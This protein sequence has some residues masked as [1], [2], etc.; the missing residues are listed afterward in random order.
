M[1][2]PGETNS[3]PEQSSINVIP[4]PV[5]QRRKIGSTRRPLKGNNVTAVSDVLQK[6]TLADAKWEKDNVSE[7]TES[8]SAVTDSDLLL[9]HHGTEGAGETD[10][11]TKQSGIS[12]IPGDLQRKETNLESSPVVQR[13]KMGSTRRPLK[14]NKG[15]RKG[16]EL[17][18]ENETFNS[19]FLLDVEKETFSLENEPCP[20]ES[21]LQNIKDGAEEQEKE[22]CLENDVGFVEESESALIQSYSSDLVSEESTALSVCNITEP[23]TLTNIQEESF[24]IFGDVERVAEDGEADLHLETESQN[25]TFASTSKA[26]ENI[27]DVNVLVREAEVI[28]GSVDSNVTAESDVL[29][30]DSLADAKLETSQVSENAEDVAAVTDSDLLVQHEATEGAEETDLTPE[31]SCISVIAGDSHRED[32]NLKSSPVVQ[33]RK[34]GSTRRPLKGNKGQRKGRELQDENETFNSEFLLNVEKETFGLENK[35]CPDESTLQDIKDK[36]EEKEK[37]ICVKN[38]AV[39]E[40]SESGHIQTSYSSDLVLEESTALSV[41]NITES[42]TLTKVHEESQ[43]NAGDVERESVDGGTNLQL[44]SKSQNQTCD[45]TS[46]T[47]ENTHAVNFLVREAEGI[48]ESVKVDWNV[49]P[50]SA[51][52]QKDTFADARLKTLQV[53]ENT[54]D[55]SAVADSDLLVQ[56]EATELSGETDSITEQSALNIIPGDSHREEANSKSSPV[57]Q[58]RKMGSTRRPLKG[59]KGQRKGRELHDENEKFNSEFLLDVEKETFSL[60][61]EPCPDESTLQNIKDGAEEQEKEICVK[62]DAGLVEESESALIQ[63]YS[64]DLVSEESTAL[65]VCNITESQT[66]TKVLEESE[67]N[68]GDVERES[69]DGGTNLQLESESQNQTCDSTSKTEENIHDVNVLVREAEVFGESVKVDCNVTAESD[70]LQKDTFADTQLKTLQ[71]SE[72]TE[73]ISAVAD[74]DLL[75]QHEATE[76]SGETDSI[77]EQSALNIIPGDSHREEANSKSSPVVQRRKMGS[78]RRPLKE[79]KGQRKGREMHDEKETIS[80][81]N[82]LNEEKE[83]FGLEDEPCPDES[84]LQNIKDGAEEQETEM[85]VK[86]DAGVIEESESAL[87]Q[88]SYG[89]DLVSEESTALRICNITESQ[90]LTEI[91]EESQENAD[92]EPVDGD[93]KPQRKGQEYPDENDTVDSKNMIKV[94]TPIFS[95]DD[96]P[97]PD[98]FT[99]ESL[100]DGAEAHKIK[101][102]MKN[103]VG[104]V[105]E[106][107]S[108]FIQLSNVSDLGPE[109]S[110]ALTVCN[111]TESQTLTNIPEESLEIVGD[112]ERKAVD[113][114]TDLQLQT[115]PHNQTFAST[116]KAEENIHDGNVLVREADVIGESVKVDSNVTAESDVLQKDT[117]ADAKLETFQLFENTDDVSAVTDSDLL[118]QHEATEAPG[119][120]DSIT[121]QSGIN[122]IP[123]GSHKE[124]ANSKSSPVVQRRKMG[125]TR[126]P[127]KGNKGQRKGR[128]MHDEKETFSSANML[129]EEKETFGL[130]DE[131]CPDESTLQNIKD[132]AAEQ[133]TEKCVKNDA[134]VVEES[135]SALIQSSY[136]SDLVSEESTALT[137]CNITESQT[138]TNIH[139]E[140][141]EIIER[142]AVDGDIDLQLEAE[143]Q[144]RTFNSTSKAEENINAVNVLVREA[145]V[146]RESDTIENKVTLESALIQN[147]IFVNANLETLKVSEKTE[148]ISADSDLLVQQE[149]ME[150]GGETN[151]IPEQSGISVIPSPVVQRRKIGSTRRPLKGNNVTAESDVLQ[152]AT[153]ADAKLEK[154]NVSE[155]TESLSAVTDSNL[156]LQHHGTEGAGETDSIPKQSGISIIPGDLQRKETNLESSPVIQRRKMGSTRRPL[157]GNKGQRKGRELHDENE[158]FN[159]EFLLDVQKETF[160]LEDEPCPD[161]STLQNI[162]DGAEEQEK[163]LCV[164]NDASLVGESESALIQSSYGS[165]LASGETTA[166]SVCNITE[167]QTLTKTHEEAWEIVGDV[168]RA[169]VEEDTDLQSKTESQ[170]QT[171]VSISE[172]EEN[173]HDVN[174][175]VREAEVTGES[176][177]LDSNVTAESDVIQKDTLADAELETLQVSENTEDVSAVTDTDFLVQHHGTERAEGTDTISVQSGIN[178]IPRESHGEE[179]NSKSSPVV[180]RRKMGSTRRPLKGNKGQRKGQELDD[181]KETF[182]CEFLLDVEKET[183][184]LENEPCPD[185]S[186]LQ[187]MKDGAEEQEKEIC[188]END[189]GL[190]EES[191]SALIQ[192]Y[193]SDLVS[194]ESTALSV[195]NITES[196]TLTKI[197]EESWEIVG[198]VERESVDGDTDLQLETESQNQTCDSTSKAEQNIHDVNVLVRE[199]EG[200]G[201]SVKVDSN[202]I[203]ESDVL[204][205]ATLADPKLETLHVSENTK[206]VS[207]VTDSDLL[208]Q[209]EPTVEAG[210]TD[211]VPEKSGISIIPG[212]SHNEEANSKSS[213]VV[214]RRKMGS[215]RRPLKGNKGQ[216]KGREL[217]DENETLNNEIR[218]DVEKETFGLENEPCPDESALQNIKVGA[219]EQEKEICVKND[220]GVVEE[221]ESDLI[222]SFYGSD[223]VSEESTALSVCH[224]E[225]AQTLTISHEQFQNNPGDAERA[226]VV[227][228]AADTEDTSETEATVTMK[229]TTNTA[230]HVFQTSPSS[231][232]DAFNISTNVEED[233]SG[234]TDTIFKQ[235]N[236]NVVHE[237]I[238]RGEAHP[239]LSPVVQKRKMGSTRRPLRG[240][241]GQKK[242]NDEKE[243]SFLENEPNPDELIYTAMGISDISEAQTHVKVHEESQDN[244][245]VVEKATVGEST[246]SQTE[247]KVSVLVREAEVPENTVVI[248]T[249]EESYLFQY[250]SDSKL[251]ISDYEHEAPVI[252]NIISKQSD[253]SIP[254]DS[255]KEEENSQL[256]PVVQKRKM[257]STR[258]PLKGN[259]GQGKQREESKVKNRDNEA[260]SEEENTETHSKDQEQNVAKDN[261]NI[262]DNVNEEKKATKA[263]DT[264][265]QELCEQEQRSDVS[266]THADTSQDETSSH[267][268]DIPERTV[269][270][271]RESTS[272]PDLVLSDVLLMTEAQTY[273]SSE[274]N[275]MGNSSISI[276]EVHEMHADSNTSKRKMGSTRKRGKRMVNEEEEEAENTIGSGAT[277]S[278][279][280]LTPKKLIAESSVHKPLFSSYVINEDHDSKSDVQTELS[281]QDYLNS[282]INTEPMKERESSPD[283]VAEM[284]SDFALGHVDTEVVPEQ[285]VIPEEPHKDQANLNPVVQKRKMG[286]TRKTLRG[287]KGQR[288]EEESKE[289]NEGMTQD[290]SRELHLASESKLGEEVQ[291]N[292]SLI[293]MTNNKEAKKPEDELDEM[294][295]ASSI[296]QFTE[297]SSETLSSS[298][299]KSEKLDSKDENDYH[300]TCEHENAHQICADATKSLQSES[301]PIERRR[302]MGS[303]RKNIGRE[304]R[305][306]R[307]RDGYEDTEI[308][309]TNLQMSHDPEMSSSGITAEEQTTEDYSNQSEDSLLG[310]IQR[311]LKTTSQSASN[312]ELIIDEPKSN[313]PE[314]SEIRSLSPSQSL[315]TL[316]DPNSPERRRRKM[317]S[318]RKNPKR[319]FKAERED[320]DK[321][322][323]KTESNKE[324]ITEGS[325]VHNI[326]ED[327]PNK[328]YLDVPSA[329]TSSQQEESDSPVVQESASPSTKR[330]FGSRRANK[331]KLGRL[332]ASDGMTESE[333][334]DH[335]PDG[336]AVED[337]QHRDGSMGCGTSVSLQPENLPFSR[338]Y[339]VAPKGTGEE[340]QVR[341]QDRMTV[342]VKNRDSK[343]VQFN[344][345][346]VGNSCVGKTSFIR[347]FHEGQFTEDYRS[348]IGV[349]TFVQTVELPD[350]TVKLQIWDTA[351]QERFHS[352]TTQVFHKAE[353]LLLM[354]EITCSKSFISIRDWIS[355]ARERAQ[356][357]VVMMLLGNKNDSV[358]REVQIQEG[359]DLAREYNIHF[360]ECSAANGANV[361]ESMRTLAELLVQRKRKREEHTTLRREPQQKKSGCC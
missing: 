180:Q 29:Q 305:M 174:V 178:I 92:G 276:T 166:L 127:L 200:I 130:E 268:L 243:I 250:V 80:S 293:N 3:I 308:I 141:W 167:P 273:L 94:E 107:E 233:T 330:K 93:F 146:T 79:N 17:H 226:A 172:A 154:D 203:A 347:R 218:F 179:A 41:C 333:D 304:G 359:A 320:E 61:N 156:L 126:R 11:N 280:T 148:D 343:V 269:D 291:Q 335:K 78:T 267:L 129:N 121:E 283:V 216:R 241:K 51:V 282:T 261:M 328:E 5:V 56:H 345:V 113:G 234:D 185:E 116:S 164:K 36:A 169:T 319:Q 74:S 325:L 64:S 211:T 289:I 302:K 47:E 89:S 312:F 266:Q 248:N 28:G 151:S 147:N 117:L 246:Q 9:Q 10:S 196:Q 336:S 158:T 168:E 189:V 274:D 277:S 360:M 150:E 231:S 99:L 353:G 72:N 213:P 25:Q 299:L 317:G 105:E 131:P 245:E 67:N 45:S 297:A 145:E 32:S 149:A 292:Q 327:P 264:S 76:V 34:M 346:M 222:Q 230:S 58:R 212:D 271:V 288:K 339:E 354:Y 97:N 238:Y 184:S 44:E 104:L 187:N 134:G 341:K 194:E 334:G 337:R 224:I 37:K 53:S 351:G 253:F 170:N 208:V 144:N 75:V 137:I 190:V 16:Q 101:M 62:N 188:L 232:T 57:V 324:E 42:Q 111:I 100:I 95:M 122:I 255:H 326:T 311:M 275:V 221:Y 7:N 249:T 69:V 217:Q 323:Q 173:I 195:C 260:G 118:I 270:F 358:N 181:E 331:G 14:G 103:D 40:E 109:E 281:D 114:D 242:D 115:E 31:Q 258:R 46:K 199:A 1:E 162:K 303:T 309:D 223:L 139:K 96:Q 63:S 98:E 2:E 23:Q 361:S 227:E 344:V 265:M 132:G 183:F 228:D 59:N 135:E 239:K 202:V 332:E 251:T 204:Q 236:I 237:D 338:N 138:L 125:S 106:S 39:V 124:E 279:E 152:K 182:H 259:K 19:E 356:D 206:D 33:R 123:G 163:E 290:Q 15:Q 83:T 294:P 318:T 262:I 193:S 355:Q 128:E 133:E 52:L 102:F 136:G 8:L 207:A 82:M 77:T 26:E 110:T 322:D 27:H 157:K 286:S 252:P 18:D 205:K 54:E 329:H 263:L 257:G 191:E 254:G 50:E 316:N 301:V 6:A 201:E 35:P 357:D 66:L 81:E 140:S 235:S 120:T 142:E 349:D 247:N 321:V 91:Q 278:K 197:Q 192:S 22:I 295:S 176:V 186:T 112:V 296:S 88:S 256:S 30:K 160:G 240:N 90:T 287:N 49:T 171:C 159:S 65:S 229:S 21:T 177:I 155:N 348:T 71:E 143:S 165:D 313:S 43:N 225:E 214:Q 70:V 285:R 310:E 298:Y 220:A 73:D 20:D 4:S 60:E 153:L 284:V 307:K 314:G 55:I 108:A 12:I 84:T 300:D 342:N 119:E 306:Q 244:H 272:Q 219:E 161:E 175:L 350:R 340:I 210:E 68:A 85:C 86:N 209:H 13:R 38:D 24:E 315:T 87:I 352:I 198:D 48:R 215:T